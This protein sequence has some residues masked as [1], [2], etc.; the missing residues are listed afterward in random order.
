[1]VMQI[2]NVIG[3]L[4]FLGNIT[5]LVEELSFGIPDLIYEPYISLKHDGLFIFTKG[6]LK[7][8]KNCITYFLSGL[9]NTVS[10]IGKAMCNSSSNMSLL[11]YDEL[12]VDVTKDLIEC[13]V[14]GISG[15]ITKPVKGAKKGL[16]G[17]FKGVVLKVW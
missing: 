4:N 10:K 9:T 2:F 15:V 17:F 16:T 7:G 12:E 14:D 3:D 13:V 1:M 5:S 6:V 11:F 8:G